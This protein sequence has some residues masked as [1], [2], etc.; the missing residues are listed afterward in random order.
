MGGHCIG[1]GMAELADSENL[2]I[3][4]SSYLECLDLGI[5]VRCE[6]WSSFL[7]PGFPILD[8]KS[9]VFS[10]HLSGLGQFMP[11]DKEGLISN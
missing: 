3:F 10:P 1:F 4:L 11:K 8:S 9:E 5:S 6:Y 7:T 2:C